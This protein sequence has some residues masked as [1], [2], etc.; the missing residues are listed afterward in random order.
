MAMNE[1]LDPGL[2]MKLRDFLK[3]ITLVVNGW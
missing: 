3:K 1:N 2:A